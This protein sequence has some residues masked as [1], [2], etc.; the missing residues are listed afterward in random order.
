MYLGLT[1]TCYDML[2]HDDEVLDIWV[3][4]IVDGHES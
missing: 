1:N 3:D 2:V 4:L